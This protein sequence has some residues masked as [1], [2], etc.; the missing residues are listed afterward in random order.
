MC[1]DAA[2]HTVKDI[3]FPQDMVYYHLAVVDSSRLVVDGND[4]LRHG[5]RQNGDHYLYNVDTGERDLLDD[6]MVHSGNNTVGSD[7]KLGNPYSPQWVC[8]GAGHV[9]FVSTTDDSSHIYCE[10]LSAKTITQVTHENGNLMEF[11]RKDGG[12]LTIAMRGNAGPELY[13]VDAQ[14]NETCLTAL[15]AALAEE[16]EVSTPETFTFTDREGNE[17]RGWVMKPIGFEAGKRYPTILQVHGGPKT[18]YGSVYFHEMQLMAAS[19]YGVIFCNPWG[20]DR[21][22]STFADIRGKYGTIDYD[23]IMQFVDACLARNP[24]IDGDRLGVAGGSYGGFMSNWIIGH[25]DRFKAA[26]SQRSIANWVSKSNTSDIGFIF[27]KDPTSTDAW[28]DVAAMW[29]HS[30]MKYADQVKTPTLFIHSDQ[31]YRCWIGEGI[32]MFSALKYFHVESRICV[33]KGENHELSRSGLP[34][35][36]IRRLKEIMDW[37]DQ[38]LK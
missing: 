11:C 8:D 23:E 27:N 1:Y 38:H 20:S 35:H 16:Y 5:N 4:T 14:G 18:V 25:T 7:V 15:N 26:A 22:G 6:S 3:S 32:Q 10:D 34:K 31:D 2:S 30:P 12:F 28:E 17:I 36:R 24:W 13:A 9:Y 37:L 29:W 19:G 33:F 21:K